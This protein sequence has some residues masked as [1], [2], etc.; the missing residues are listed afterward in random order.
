M[1]KT[2]AA[3]QKEA[4]GRPPELGHEGAGVGRAV[5]H[6]EEG[7]H[8]LPLVSAMARRGEVPPRQ[9]GDPQILT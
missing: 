2:R 4:L 7:D 6:V 3:I 1:I 8:V 9:T 5:D